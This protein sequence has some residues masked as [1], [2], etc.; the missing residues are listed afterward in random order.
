[1]ICK[2]FSAALVVL[3]SLNRPCSQHETCREKN[4]EELAEIGC[5]LLR[6]AFLNTF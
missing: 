1:M 3:E 5:D 6:C 4:R 2:G